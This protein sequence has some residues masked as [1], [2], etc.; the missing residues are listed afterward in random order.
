ML[1]APCLPLCA[2]LDSLWTSFLTMRCIDANAAVRKCWACLNSGKQVAS[3][4]WVEGA[5]LVTP[6]S[7]GKVFAKVVCGKCI[8]LTCSKLAF[9]LTMGGI[10]NGDWMVL[11]VVIIINSHI[12]SDL[13][14]CHK[15][16]VI[17]TQM[18]SLQPFPLSDI[19]MAPRRW[20]RLHS[21]WNKFG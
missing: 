1:S 20:Q 21:L 15:F 19:V 3:T 17:V 4:N 12:F 11:N 14:I 16:C 18:H 5:Q 9:K 2:W 8:H 7:H 10:L 6:E 13:Y